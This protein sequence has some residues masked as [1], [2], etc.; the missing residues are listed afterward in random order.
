MVTINNPSHY[1]FL[2]VEPVAKTPYP[3]LGLMKISSMLKKK[4]KG[5]EISSRIGY[6]Y[7]PANK[8]PRTIYIT[9]L[10]TWDYKILLNTISFYQKFYPQC[11][12]NVGGIAASMLSD[13]IYKNTGIKPHIGLY[14]EA[15]NFPPDYSQNFGRKLK[16]SISFTSRGCIR[17]CHFCSV[18]KMEPEFQVRNKWERDIDINLPYITFWDNNF[19]AS[20]NFE[21]ECLKIAMY[22]KTV[23]FNQGLD[24]RLYTDEK[25]KLL[26]KIRL[27]PIRL[28]FDNIKYEK[29]ILRAIKTAKKY[30]TRE[31][32]VYVLYNFEDTPEDFYYRINLLNKE[33]VLSFPMGYRPPTADTR[34]F[35]DEHW[36][37]FML[38]ALKL[39]LLFYYRKGMITESRNSFLSIYGKNEKEFVN[40]LYKIYEYD[41]SL[42][43]S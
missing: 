12:M 43:R 38:R 42:K 26:S 17:R 7:I 25:A 29:Y 30:S 37:S 21:S 4:Y 14:D 2:L 5:C 9:S 34:S 22:D 41:K 3:P 11:N 6:D 1:K 15:E 28:A 19:L 18:K 10:F 39:S 8:I 27:N 16:T 32:C 40:K 31:I 13:D 35:P 23:D 36:D 20:P 33:K 24:A